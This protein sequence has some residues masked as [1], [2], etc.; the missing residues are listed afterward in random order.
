M[1]INSNSVGLGLRAPYVKN[2]LEHLPSVEW[3]EVHSENYYS[4]QGEEFKNLI[5]MREHYPVS[6]HC[7]GLSVGSSQELSSSA[8]QSLKALV[9]S[10]E[11]CLVSTHLSWSF[12]Q[13]I[14]FHDLLPIPY[15]E[16]SLAVVSHH[17]H[18]IQEVIQRP[19]LMEN[20]TSYITFKETELA[21]PDFLNALCAMTGCGLLLDLNNLYVNHQ[22]HPEHSMW[23]P[24]KYMEKLSK[25]NVKEIH[26]AGFT[27]KET[28]EGV[29]FLDTHNQCV[30]DSV[31]SLYKMVLEQWEPI[32]TLIEWDSDFPSFSILLEEA[33]KA[34]KYMEQNVY[35]TL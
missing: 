6:L 16:E 29:I 13:D 2:I 28:K 23:E 27:E 1:P 24:K 15:T 17:I 5:K 11:P 7:V 3:F 20:I 12:I 30:S 26:L 4:Q 14:Y 25:N 19:I 22:N 34:K 18:Q 10:I 8:L 32:P 21:E 33:S 35:E 31:W 9:D